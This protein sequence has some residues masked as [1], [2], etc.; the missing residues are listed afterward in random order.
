[1]DSSRPFGRPIIAEEDPAEA[2]SIAAR[3]IRR[4]ILLGVAAAA[5]VFFLLGPPPRRSYG[6]PARTNP[7]EV[8][9]MLAAWL[10]EAETRESGRWAGRRPDPEE[11][12]RRREDAR[13]RRAGLQAPSVAVPPPGPAPAADG[14]IDLNAASAAEIDA[15]VPGF[16]EILSARLVHAR[17]A[18][19]WRSWGEVEAVDGIGARRLALLR[20]HA[21]L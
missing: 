10:A 3:E 12:E 19:G 2:L 11:G 9:A 14:P 5:T 18:A 15:R 1:M 17:P 16:G 20:R 4:A 8:D 21:R 13:T 6:P 7:G